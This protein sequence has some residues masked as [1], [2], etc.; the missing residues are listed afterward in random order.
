M[1]TT[2]VTPPAA[3]LSVPEAKSSLWVI[4]GSRKW[5]W[6]SMPPGRISASPYRYTGSPRSCFLIATIVPSST[7]IARGSIR[8]SRY[9]RPST[10]SMLGPQVPPRDD[11]PG[12][13]LR[14]DLGLER[15]DPGRVVE[16]RVREE[17]RLHARLGEELLGPPAELDRHLREQQTPGR[18]LCDDEP[19]PPDED[20]LRV[21]LRLLHLDELGAGE[22]GDLDDD[23][24]HLVLREGREPRVHAGALR[25]LH[26]GLDQR[27]E[28][29]RVADAAPEVPLRVRV[30]G[31]ERARPR[32]EPLRYRNR[33]ERAPADVAV[34][35][36]PRDLHRELA[37]RVR[38]RHRIRNP[39]DFLKRS[40]RTESQPRAIGK[41]IYRVGPLPAEMRAR[42][43]VMEVMSKTPV[44]ATPDDTV[45]RAAAVMRTKDIG[46]LIVVENER[47]IGIVT[48][49]DIV[50]KVAAANKVPASVRVRDIMSSPVVAVGPKEE[51][52]QAARLMS[53]RKIRRLAVV[54]NGK[55][56]G[57]VTEN[58]IVRIWPDLIEITREYARLGLDEDVRGIEGHCEACGIYSTNLVLD[59]RLLL[60]PECRVS[61]EG[62]GKLSRH[63]Y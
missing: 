56:L 33:R 25:G 22:E 44:T 10:T 2:V 8:P 17:A 58:Y 49:R 1:S 34:D 18:A 9:A 16:P 46:S 43:P 13:H 41:P 7:P 48:E 30:Q 55:L 39:A 63:V 47:P 54:D 6:M 27:E 50:T 60:C 19:V 21:L 42:V 12:F 11:S 23:A 24:A 31:D 32:V 62:T 28:R 4:P 35:G 51:V 57:V 59:R 61:P 52:V 26:E 3:A 15:V 45:D 36:L 29:G 20:H 38:V 40:R 5:T 37:L 14:E 53:D